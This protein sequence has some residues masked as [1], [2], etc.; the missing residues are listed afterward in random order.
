MAYGNNKDTGQHMHQCSL[1]SDLL[2]HSLDS[3][4]HILDKSKIPKLQIASVV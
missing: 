1:I 2:V 4:I 3:I